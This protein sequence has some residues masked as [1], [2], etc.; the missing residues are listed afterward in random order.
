MSETKRKRRSYTIQD[1]IS[2]LAK[3]KEFNGNIAKVSRKLNI[4]RKCLCEWRNNEEKIVNL[5]HKRKLR[6]IG[7]GRK[8]F[9]K[10]LE[11]KLHLGEIGKDG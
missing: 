6:K 10:Q 8:P 9:F 3:I 4:D 5:P 1:K 11:E 7:C 2:A